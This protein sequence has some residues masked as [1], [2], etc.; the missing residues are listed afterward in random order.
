VHLGLAR[1]RG[2][3]FRIGSAGAALGLPAVELLDRGVALAERQPGAPL[4][5]LAAEA[6]YADQAH[7]T[8]ECGRL[9]GHSPAA[10]LATGAAPAGEKS[11]PFK[12]HGAAFATLAA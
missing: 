3:R 5:R 8:R 1:P 4:S 9:S 10:L 12:P 6:G 11:D 7:L 2:V